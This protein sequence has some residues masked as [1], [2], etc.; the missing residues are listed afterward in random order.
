MARFIR[1][2]L[3]TAAIIIAAAAAGI[4]ALF[5]QVD[6]VA[7][8]KGIEN[9]ARESLNAQVEFAGDISLEHL[10]DLKIS[11]PSLK[12]TSL[13]DNKELFSIQAGTAEVSLWPIPLG[14]IRVKSAEISGLQTAFALTEPSVNA[15]FETALK[16]INFPDNLRVGTLRLVN[17]SLQVTVPTQGIPVQYQ[18]ND[19]ALNVSSLSPEM[20]TSFEARAAFSRIPA[21]TNAETVPDRSQE[22]PSQE[23]AKPENTKSALTKGSATEIFALDSGILNASGTLG[24][25]ASSRTVTFEAVQFSLE[26]EQHSERQSLVGKADKLRFKDRDVHGTNVSAAVSR[27]QAVSGDIHLSA[28]DFRYTPGSF[29]SPELSVSYTDQQGERLTTLE[30]ISSVDANIASQ[31]IDM[32]NFTGRVTVSGDKSLPADF[33]A[34]LSGVIHADVAKDEAQVELSGAF[35]GA[36][37]TY[38]GKLSNR[39]APMLR[40]ELMIGS[41]DMKTLPQVKS[42]QWMKYADFQGELRID[43]IISGPFNATGLHS[44]L[45]VQK[46]DAAFSNVIVNLADG[47]L[48]GEGTLLNDGAWQF[49]SKVDGINL[50]K[51]LLLFGGRDVV[52]G[53]ANGS[54]KMHGPDLTGNGAVG[55]SQIRVLRGL[56]TGLDAAAMKNCVVDNGDPTLV[57]KEGT[58]TAMD[59]TRADISLENNTVTVTDLV[60]RSVNVRSTGNFTISLTD[61]SISGDTRTTF[62]PSRGKPSVIVA[63][64]LSGQASAPVWNFGW[65][66]AQLSYKRAQ[67]IPVAPPAENKKRSIWQS[68]KDFFSF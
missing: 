16:S 10:P 64:S 20:R 36:P 13:A 45:S 18:I 68:V 28:V 34:S 43:Q 50:G 4:A 35:A 5:Y 25:S 30:V 53:L 26:I 62:A 67:G 32:D 7:I 21:E 22:V 66:D 17:A 37:F 61:G 40:G 52:T 65:E 15:L 14:A 2:F 60:S 19:A 29:A 12:F 8:K 33:T 31:R 63:A 44:N 58:Q 3:L 9:L 47:R 38:N 46:G 49:S 27:P 56:Y 24:L 55:S 51:L 23:Q 41:L 1:W 39:A 48:L 6:E 57:Q 11:L 59:D 42:L 54:L